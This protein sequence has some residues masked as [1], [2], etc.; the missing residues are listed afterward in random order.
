MWCSG[1]REQSDPLADGFG[2]QGRVPETFYTGE[3]E[4]GDALGVIG[5][6]CE[7]QGRSKELFRQPYDI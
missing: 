7:R 6:V 1:E 3:G 5:F 2:K 4:K